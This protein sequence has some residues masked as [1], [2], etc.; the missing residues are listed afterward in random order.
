MDRT[1][2]T[3]LG[4]ATS[5][6]YSGSNPIQTG[7]A[8]GTIVATRAAV[9]RGAVRGRDGFPIPGVTITI[10]NHPEFG[11]TRT[12]PDG[13]FDLAVNGGGPLNSVLMYSVQLYTVAFKYF[14]MGYASAMAWILF[15]LLFV[16]TLAAVRLSRRFVHYE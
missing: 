3:T 9:L 6:L 7:V 4:Q 1:V 14:Q 15:A 8:P 10:L 16:L 12:R 11:Q 2:A 13:M 5:F